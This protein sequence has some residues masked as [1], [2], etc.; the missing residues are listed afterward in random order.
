[1]PVEVIVNGH[2]AA[3]KTLTA[4]G[5]VRSFEIP[6]EVEKSSWIAVRIL[7]SVHTNPVFVHVGGKPIHTDKRSADWCAE[8]VRTC[9]NSKKNSIR[10]SERPE[11]EKAYRQA[12]EIYK[13]IAAAFSGQ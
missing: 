8:A 6:V 1:M 4:D 5:G 12:E 3:T 10:E 9:W 7:P 13:S 2:V 11:A